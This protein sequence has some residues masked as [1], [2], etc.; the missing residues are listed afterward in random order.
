MA[1]E[2]TP[3]QRLKDRLSKIEADQKELKT[4]RELAD[5][6]QKD[7]DLHSQSLQIR[8]AELDVKLELGEVS[9]AS[10]ASAL[11]E[12]EAT[13]KLL[14]LGTDKLDQQNQQ[15]AQEKDLIQARL[16]RIAGLEEEIGLLRTGAGEFDKWAN[17][18]AA[19]AGI[20]MKFTQ[21]WSGGLFNIGSK[22]KKV[23]KE[24]ALMKEEGKDTGKVVARAMDSINDALLGFAVE[25]METIIGQQDQLAAGFYKTTQ[26]SEEMANSVMGASEALRAQG[27]GMEA[28]YK[29][30][31]ALI[32]S[33]V[34]FKNATGA[35][36]KEIINTVAQLEVAGVSANTTAAAFDVFTK[37]LGKKG[38]TELKKFANVAETLDVPL[39]QF[40]S[41]FVTASKQ[42]ASR[43]PQMEKI[44]VNLQAQVR[45]TGA[46][47]DTLLQVANR[48]DTFDSSAEAVARLNGILGG[49]YLNSVEMVMMKED[50]RIEAVRASLKQSGTVFKNLGHHAQMSIMAA[51][52]ITDQA[53]ANKLLGSS[54]SEYKKIQKEAQI[55][56][57]KEK[58]LADM[59]QKAMTMMEELRLAVM[60]LVIEMKPLI[61]WVTQ[62][63]SSFT[64][65]LN[66]TGSTAKAVGFVTFLVSALT[67]KILGATG[68]LAPMVIGLWKW[69]A[70][71]VALSTA[72][73]GLAIALT[74]I[75]WTAIVAAI[76][77]M[78]AGVAWL[79]KHFGWWGDS[80]EEAGEKVN[81][82]FGKIDPDAQKEAMSRVAQQWP[83]SS[84]AEDASSPLNASPSESIFEATARVASE[85]LSK[86]SI[87]DDQL[88]KDF[89]DLPLRDQRAV[90]S[91]LSGV[92]AMTG[93]KPASGG[94]PI[95]VVLKLN[96][97]ELGSILFDH[98]NGMIYG[99]NDTGRK[100]NLG[101]SRQ[102]K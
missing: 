43:G 7:I 2:E 51:A 101:L 40:Y 19:L 3:E 90:S 68:A 81:G 20:G 80:A 14:A 70:A 37:V 66:T 77:A 22:I 82:A 50:E 89:N 57:D 47:M 97:R 27:L 55:A 86:I 54:A 21:T 38:T 13:Y 10:Y 9:A 8:R 52:G 65:F 29:A 69:V 39:N 84:P 32:A 18:T 95:Q 76:T 78:I 63:I 56:A 88:V 79:T 75:G 4:K 85:D 91:M 71:K 92:S 94:Q 12:I 44:F 83:H 99:E 64:G 16:D 59:A 35:Y 61:N 49:T 23:Q 87:N 6:M 98:P 93:A 15:L 72:T 33:S 41:E 74:A 31:E 58:N 46:S 67:L 26:A 42:L 34:E 17:K 1:K 53:E 24:F 100:L 60:G 45:A 36:R 48:F 11:K 25:W 73:G 96:E 62:A 28:S 30:S 5:V 102:T